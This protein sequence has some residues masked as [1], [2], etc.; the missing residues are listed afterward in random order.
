M[1]VFKKADKKANIHHIFLNQNL[2]RTVSFFS[3]PSVCSQAVLL[4]NG[5]IQQKKTSVYVLYVYDK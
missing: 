5:L 3:V 4:R 1:L 2:I